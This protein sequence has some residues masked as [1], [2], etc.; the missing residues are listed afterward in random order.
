VGY[1]NYLGSLVTEDER[2]QIQDCRGKINDQQEGN[3]SHQEI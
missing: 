3:I 2:N 1:F